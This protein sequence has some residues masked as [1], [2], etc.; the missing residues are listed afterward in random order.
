MLFIYVFITLPTQA[1]SIHFETAS[2]LEVQERAAKDGKLYYLYFSAQWCAPCQWMEEN[3]FRDQALSA[4][5][6][7]HYLAVKLDID[8]KEA[9][10]YQDK[11]NVTSIP[12]VL[13]FSAG[14]DLLDQQKGS[15]E[16]SEFLALLQQYNT[17]QHQQ[18]SV[19]QADVAVLTA[20]QPTFGISK[21][22]LVTRESQIQQ[23]ATLQAPVPV[24]AAVAPQRG[25][26]GVFIPKS[27]EDYYY[28][29]VDETTDYSTAI[30][31]VKDYEAKVN[32]KVQLFTHKVGTGLVYEVAIGQFFDKSKAY[33]FLNYINRKDISGSIKKHANV[34]I[35]N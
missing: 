11:F 4:Y 14:G 10:Y 28:V 23:E 18:S 25:Q 17:T 9:A 22:A 12:T 1:N 29:A 6:N 30:Q 5:S 15:L 16:A 27:G 33:S 24:M 7:R 35:T 3:T 34:N 13:I 8:N 26:P 19:Q 2:V 21:P 31:L 20:P 32:D